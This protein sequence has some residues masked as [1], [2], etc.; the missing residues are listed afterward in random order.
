MLQLT[1]GDIVQK[2]DFMLYIH[3]DKKNPN[4]S[5]YECGYEKCAPDHSFGPRERSYYLLHFVVKGKGVLTVNNTEYIIRE[6]NC[7]LIPAGVKT[8]YVADHDDPWEYYW[9]GMQGIEVKDILRHA[10][11]TIYTPVIE[12]KNPSILFS[13]IESL[14]T[15]K[16]RTP[17]AKYSVMGYLYQIIGELVQESPQVEVNQ[18]SKHHDSINDFIRYVEENYQSNITISEYTDL[19]KIERTAFTKL[20]TKQWNISPKNYIIDYRLSKALLLLKNPNYNVLQVS[21]MVGYSDY[22]H[23]LK[24][25][26]DKY[27][28]TPKMYRKDPFETT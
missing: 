26:K 23:F 7:F 13:L 17:G 28:V 12:L 9:I 10:A 20:F 14:I 5:L 18:S 2:Q 24:T 16:K 22:K 11:L 21:N 15:L 6:N 1:R 8:K 19:K 4:I 27:K 3:D 25:F